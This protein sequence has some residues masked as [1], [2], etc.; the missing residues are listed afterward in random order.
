MELTEFNLRFLTALNR[1]EAK[2]KDTSSGSARHPLL[3]LS[4]LRDCRDDIKSRGLDFA[5][6]KWRSF[7]E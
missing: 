7:V 2:T 6:K 3:R 4:L 1:I 5:L